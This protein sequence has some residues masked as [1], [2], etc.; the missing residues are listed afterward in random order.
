MA[1]SQFTGN[2]ESRLCGRKNSQK[3]KTDAD[4]STN[5]ASICTVQATIPDPQLWWPNGFGD[6]NLYQLE[7]TLESGKTILDR[8]KY[9]L[10]LRTLELRRQP[11]KWGES[12]TFVVNGVPIFAK[13]AD[14][15]PADFSP[16]VSAP[17]TWKAW[18][19]MPR[20]RT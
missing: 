8:Q 10:G 6:Q 4:R 13:G 1:G 5:D 18:S 14:W 9:Q 20:R 3:V 16:P 15:I 7:V 12:F 17:L 11:D 19:V 2:H